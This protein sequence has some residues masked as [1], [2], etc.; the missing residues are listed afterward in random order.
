M[1]NVLTQYI[2]TD[3]HTQL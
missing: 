1:T 3:A 2:I